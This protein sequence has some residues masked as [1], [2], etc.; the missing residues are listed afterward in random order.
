MAVVMGIGIG[1]FSNEMATVQGDADMNIVYWQLKLA[2]ETAINQRRSVEVRF[3]PPNFI[4][5]VRHNM[6]N[7][8]TLVVDGVLEHNTPFMLFPGMPDTP[9][10]FGNHDRHRFRR[11]R[12]GDV[13]GGRHVH[14]PGRQPR[15]RHHLPRPAGQAAD[16]A[17]LTV[18]GPTA[19]HPHVSLERLG[20]ETLDMTRRSSNDSGFT[21]IEV[22]VAMIMLMV[23]V[24]A[25]AGGDR[26]RRAADH[27]LAGSASSPASARPRRPRACSRRATTACCTW[28]QIR[29]VQGGVGHRR[30]RLPRRPAATSAIPAPTASSTRPTTARWSTIVKPGPD[31]LLGTADDIAHAALRVHA[32]DRDSRHQRDA[33]AASRDRALPHVDGPGAVRPDHLPVLLCVNEPTPASRSPKRWSRRR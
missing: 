3:T 31:G 9:D 10:G 27:R 22:I 13:H 5:V 32:R 2:R 1:S 18:F 26:A 4:S 6:P 17:R 28:A 8:T 21:L 24:L 33:P 20:V 15:Q 25:L 19:T 30:R 11:R 23:G 12:A 7:G 29:N 16:R 14:R